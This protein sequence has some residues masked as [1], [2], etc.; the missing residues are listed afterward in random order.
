MLLPPLNKTIHRHLIAGALALGINTILIS[1][2]L[3]A[4]RDIPV[5]DTPDIIDI[6]FVSLPLIEPEPDPVV[7]EEEEAEQEPESVEDEADTLGEAVNEIAEPIALSSH[8]EEEEEEASPEE[9]V[10]RWQT[11]EAQPWPSGPGSTPF[12]LREVFCLTSSEATRE[13]GH[14]PDQPN[15]DGLAMLRYA[16]NHDLAAL[17]EAFGLDLSPEQIRALFGEGEHKLSGQPTVDNSRRPTS[18][19]DEMRDTLPPQHPDPGFGD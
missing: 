17:Q 9:L 18:S 15:E 7:E 11:G 2:I 5:S 14:C 3:F 4:P 1:F 10:A 8:D 16:G 6:V 19:A 13:A 12:F